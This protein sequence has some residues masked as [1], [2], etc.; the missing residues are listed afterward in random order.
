MIVLSW[1]GLAPT[2]VIAECSENYRSGRSLIF[3]IIFLLLTLNKS[4]PTPHRTPFSTS[5]SLMTVRVCVTMNVEQ[6]I[7][8]CDH[9]LKTLKQK[10]ELMPFSSIFVSHS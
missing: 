1:E 5:L 7:K 3:E 6:P 9:M 8:I 10:L 4:S 2:K